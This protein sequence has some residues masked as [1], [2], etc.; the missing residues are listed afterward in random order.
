[1]EAINIGSRREVCWDETLMDTCE[2]VH[3]KM[4]RPEYRND[5]LVCDK[6]WEGN[7]SGYFVLLPD[8]GQFR[9]Y[10]RGSQWDVNEDGTGICSY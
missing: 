4:R 2:G 9:L 6:P 10:Y 7:C 1:M 8:C 5:A 3:V